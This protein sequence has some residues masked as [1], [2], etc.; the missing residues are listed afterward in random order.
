MGAR[1]AACARRYAPVLLKLLKECQGLVA[2]R[3]PSYNVNG[4][5][6]PA[7]LVGIALAL[8]HL[9]R[10]RKGLKCGEL[11]LPKSRCDPLE[12]PQNLRSSA[13]IQAVGMQARRAS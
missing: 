1:V 13:S 7:W 5:T 2:G 8:E 3:S 4:R 12:S 11:D 10:V 6:Q 9:S